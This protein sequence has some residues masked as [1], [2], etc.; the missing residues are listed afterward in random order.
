M[1]TH[2]NCAD[3]VERHLQEDGHRIWGW[4]MYR[5]TYESEDDW[6]EFMRRLCF[7]ICDTL[8]FNNGLGL[9]DSLD[10]HI[11]EDKTQFDG[12][13]PSQI[14]EH[15]EQWTATAAEREQDGKGAGRSQRYQFCLH[16]DASALRSVI[17]GPSPPE[18]CL[19][20]GY[21]NLICKRTSV[22][23]RSEYTET[24]DERDLCWMRISYS[25]LMVTWYSKWRRDESRFH[26]YRQPPGV[27]RP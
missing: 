11:F 7:Y 13:H 3:I 20:D 26:A 22:P 6:D 2:F 21:V 5:C 9:L 23:M 16:V 27:G 18:D 14:R 8:E 1:S 12:A 4:V 17:D 24:P 10:Y 15:F 25:G 19:G